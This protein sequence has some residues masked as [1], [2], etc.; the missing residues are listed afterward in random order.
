MYTDYASMLS[1][2]VLMTKTTKVEPTEVE[3]CLTE[4]IMP[5]CPVNQNCNKFA[6]Y[7]LENYVT[8]DSKITSDMWAGI[9]SKEKRT[10]NGKESFHAHFNM[11]LSQPFSYLTSCI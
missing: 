9:P 6:E 10:N 11:H 1:G 3:D 7:L 2:L 5:D 8:F 4:D